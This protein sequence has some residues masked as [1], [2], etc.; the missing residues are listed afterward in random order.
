MTVQNVWFAQASIPAL[1]LLTLNQTWEML[2]Q[3]MHLLQI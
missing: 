3:S 2:Q 1:A